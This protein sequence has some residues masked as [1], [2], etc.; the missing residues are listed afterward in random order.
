MLTPGARMHFRHARSSPDLSS[1]VIS[2]SLWPMFLKALCTEILSV[3][4][5][6]IFFYFNKTRAMKRE[7]DEGS[8][9]GVIATCHFIQLHFNLGC[10]EE[11]HSANDS[12]GGV[13]ER[14]RKGVEIW[15]P[16]T[17]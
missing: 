14:W 15:A 3:R 5:F 16:D 11:S 17:S 13:A 9:R 1:D 6:K 10:L 4:F 7:R 8:S 2:I 12:T